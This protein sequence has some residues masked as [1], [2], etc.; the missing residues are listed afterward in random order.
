GARML[1]ADCEL[2]QADDKRTGDHNDA[3]G[4][5]RPAHYVPAI[6]HEPVAAGA[7]HETQE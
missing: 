7:R 5:R 4:D 6:L 2:S 1:L 3:F